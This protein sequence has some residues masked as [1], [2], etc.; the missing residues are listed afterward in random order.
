L[1]S[2]E[3]EALGPGKS[4]CPSVGECQGRG[5]R[6][7]WRLEEHLYRSRERGEGIGGFQRGNLGRE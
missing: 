5:W 4:G 1:S 2:M 3:G 7:S 6:E